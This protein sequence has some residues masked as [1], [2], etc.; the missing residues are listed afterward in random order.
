M[1]VLSHKTK[2]VLSG[3]IINAKLYF[4]VN[5]GRGPFPVNIQNSLFNIKMLQ[6][7]HL[8]NSHSVY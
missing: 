3:R 6:H 8:L 7:L 2:L 4:N 5:V 1:Q